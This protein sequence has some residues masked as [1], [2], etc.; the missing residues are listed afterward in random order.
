[1]P[2]TGHHLSC[3]MFENGRDYPHVDQAKSGSTESLT[4]IGSSGNLE[5]L[6]FLIQS[7]C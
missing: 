7:F 5:F 2:S 3:E 6:P 4:L 1:M